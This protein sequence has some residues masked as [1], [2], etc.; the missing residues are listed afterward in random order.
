M[1]ASVQQAD[2][3]V[4]DVRLGPFWTAVVVQRSGSLRCGLASAMRHDQTHSHDGPEPVGE[5]GHLTGC[6]ALELAALARSGS[7]AGASTGLAAINALLPLD[8][9]A[10]VEVNAE[11]VLWERAA[12]RRVAVIGHFPFVSRLG[13]VVR[14]LWVLE[15][16][17]GSGDLPAQ[18]APDIIPQADAV[19]ITGTTLINHLRR[20]VASLQARCLCTGLEPHHT[21]FPHPL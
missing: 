12:G 5:A 21:P 8:E 13:S 18:A 7:V 2:A 14:E 20:A 19:S 1:L 17:P 15:Q 11:Q 4:E 3:R 6:T 10:C 9:T 16:H